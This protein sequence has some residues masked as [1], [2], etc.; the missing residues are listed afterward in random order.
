[1]GHSPSHIAG[2]P[3]TDAIKHADVQLQDV[4]FLKPNTRGSEKVHWHLLL[5]QE[6]SLMKM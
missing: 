6:L 2:K 3:V 1:M 5:D 4:I